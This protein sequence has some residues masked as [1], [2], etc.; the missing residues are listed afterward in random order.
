MPTIAD[1]M[2][3][4]QQIAPLELA[5]EWDNVGLLAG[6]PGA[7]LSRVLTCLTL[8]PDVVAEAIQLGVNL[9]VSHH[10]LPFRG[11][12]SFTTTT[13]DGGSLWR[14]LGAGIGVYSPHTAYDSAAGGINAQW[15]ERLRLSDVQPLAPVADRTDGAGIG[16]VGHWNGDFTDLLEGVQAVTNTAAVRV[17]KPMESET[18]AVAIACG[19]GGSMLDLAVSAEANVFLTGEMSFHDCLRCR[20][21]GIGVILTGHFASERFAVETL[22][23]RLASALPETD[24]VASRVETDPLSLA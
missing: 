3:L 7:E 6:D 20:S 11:V 17:V 8:T 2:H 9:V 12:K 4:L 23:E 18:Y 1:A 19:S 22:A 5:E 16:R 21:L 24:V 13:V 10:P 14:L 15:A